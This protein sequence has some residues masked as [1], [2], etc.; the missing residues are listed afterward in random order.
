MDL[1]SSFEPFNFNH[2]K[3]F[4]SKCLRKIL[5]QLYAVSPST[6]S[7]KITISFLSKKSLKLPIIQY[8]TSVLKIIQSFSLPIYYFIPFP[9]TLEGDLS[10]S[11]VLLPTKV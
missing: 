7:I 6:H 5:T 8:S 3:T 9:V 2:I 10:A 1:Q 4:Q 11:E